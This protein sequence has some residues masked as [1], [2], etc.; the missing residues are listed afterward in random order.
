MPRVRRRFGRR[1][2][3]ARR[4]APA[5]HPVKRRPAPAATPKSTR[6][7]GRRHPERVCRTEKLSARRRDHGQEG[8]QLV[9]REV[10]LVSLLSRI[11]CCHRSGWG[12]GNGPDGCVQE[13]FNDCRVGKERL[14]PLHLEPSCQYAVRLCFA[15]WSG[16]GSSSTGVSPCGRSSTGDAGGEAGARSAARSG[17]V[18]QL[19]GPAR[20]PQRLLHPGGEG[21]RFAIEPTRG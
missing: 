18:V 4:A 15:R 7:R 20:H 5:L 6:P 13:R 10:D 17:V 19:L 8:R 2:A 3:P 21:I 1:R 16:S 12:S 14:N 9:R 11:S